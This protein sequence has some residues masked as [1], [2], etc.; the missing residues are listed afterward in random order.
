MRSANPVDD[1]F[2][3]CTS[4]ATSRSLRGAGDSASSASKGAIQRSY[5]SRYWPLR[6]ALMRLNPLGRCRFTYGFSQC[7]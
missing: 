2:R 3:A 4:R 5:N 1:I 7:W 6:S